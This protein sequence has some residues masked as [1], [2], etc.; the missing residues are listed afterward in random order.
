M[1]RTRHTLLGGA[2]AALFV[3]LR[4]PFL[5]PS[6]EDLDS[7][8]F[9]LGVHH[10]DVAQHQPHPPG[11]PV[12][13]ALA[14]G[15]HAAGLSEA[16]ALA[17][18]GIVGAALAVWVLVCWLRVVSARAA[19]SSAPVW[20]AAIC[21][22]AP[23][24]WVTA[25]R[26]LSDAVGLAAALT[27]QWLVLRASSPRALAA[28]AAAAGLALGFRSQVVWLTAP[29]LL[30]AVLWRMPAVSRVRA[31]GA[32]VVAG[33]LG[34][35]A[36]AVPLVWASGGVAAYLRA[37]YAQGAEDL[38]GVVML[39]TTPTLRQLVAALQMAFVTPWG[40]W[41]L[42]VLALALA[43]AGLRW[44]ARH[45]RL[46]LVYLALAFGPYLI[47]DIVFQET[48]TTRYALPLVVPVAVL[49]GLGAV[50]IPWRAGQVAG[51]VLLLACARV[52]DAAA[53]GY[54]AAPAP[55]VRMLADM[56]RASRPDGAVAP[57]SPVLAM[58]R[59]EYF[60]LRRSFQWAGAALPAFTRRLATP[61]KH[62][63]LE[64]VRYWNSGGREPVWFV[65]DPLRS[66][67][68]L[69]RVRARPT[70]YRYGFPST[71]LI[72]GTRP[73]EMDWWQLERPDWYL[74]EGWA[75][76]PETAGIARE[77]QKG[78]G[79][80]GIDGWVRRMPDGG[81][82]L[83]GGRHLGHAATARLHV[84]VDEVPALDDRVSPGF[85]LRLVAMPA[86][87]GAGEYAHVR[88]TSDEPDLAIE[89]FD[90]QPTGR[91]VAGFGDGWNEPEYNPRTGRLWRWSSDR[92]DLRVRAEGHALAL[93]LG[94]ELEAAASSHVTVRANGVIAAQFD[95]PTPFS[96]T[97]L[98][99]A[100]LVTTPE[101]VLTIESSAWY[102][103]ADTRWRSRDHRR[104]GLKLFECAVTPAS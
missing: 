50:A 35:L 14:K 81:T 72:G 60:D 65:A 32:S 66:D 36:W 88:V 38:S 86:G 33:A 73:S 6:L 83:I 98:V 74:G 62:E 15:L 2:A 90:A 40:A 55:A 7:I 77:D 51:V 12:Y 89:Q 9:A 102:V 85:F 101:S 82:L 54:A 91:V 24:Y 68:A 61:P 76:T 57:L 21:G 71:A 17:L 41:P 45:D 92:A 69:W 22:V 10:F 84:T 48:V 75:V 26:P 67:L 56:A 63:W 49:A 94:G 104:L 100:A 42:A 11:Y 19:E 37:V 44:A 25:G 58:H 30:S 64:V 29:L 18:P 96:R 53:S 31:L 3:A 39:A 95:V 80:G 93:T 99:P 1:T 4:L 16:H 97:V 23:L 78:P 79:L 13:I 34:V 70:T 5:P 47:F 46:L 43:V 28:A 8:N 20:A 59:R 27:V 103:P 87:G 52:S